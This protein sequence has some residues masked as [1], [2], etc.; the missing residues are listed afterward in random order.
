M[1][2]VKAAFVEA[3]G[4]V[5]D[6]ITIDV[7]RVKP[8]FVEAVGV[9]V[10]RNG[11]RINVVVVEAADAVGVETVD[12]DANRNNVKQEADVEQND[13]IDIATAITLQASWDS[14]INMLTVMATMKT[15]TK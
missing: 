15:A 11:K 12:V 9:D 2:G 6:R 13:K 1:V 5:V 14:N 3:A 10:N 7:V 4:V 8:A